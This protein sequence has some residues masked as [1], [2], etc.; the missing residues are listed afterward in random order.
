MAD[1]RPLLTLNTVAVQSYPFPYD[2]HVTLQ[3]C[4]TV[5]QIYIE[6]HSQNL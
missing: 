6:R 4:V 3:G 2:N 5:K 1:L